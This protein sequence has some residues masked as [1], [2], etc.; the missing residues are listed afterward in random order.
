MATNIKANQEV[1][2]VFIKDEMPQ[3]KLNP[4]AL[5]SR[6]ETRPRNENFERVLRTEIH[7]PMFMLGR[8]WQLGEFTAEDTGSAIFAKI[9]MR[10]ASLSRFKAMNGAVEAFDPSIPLETKVER[11]PIQFNYKERVRMGDIWLKYVQKHGIEAWGAAFDFV[12]VKDDFITA[13]GFDAPDEITDEDSDADLVNKSKIISNTKLYEYLRLIAGRKIDGKLIYDL[14]Q[15][16][17]PEVM[18]DYGFTEAY[19]TIFEAARQDLV[20]WYNSAY[21]QPEGETNPCWNE[22]KYE[23]S[24]QAALPNHDNSINT[25]LDVEGYHSGQLRWKDFNQ[26]TNIANND[27]LVDPTYSA[28]GLAAIEGAALQ[29]VKTV[30]LLPVSAQFEG[31]ASNRWWQ[32]EN[33]KV[34]FGKMDANTTD[35]A[36]VVAAEFTFVHQDDWFV[37]PYEVP[38]GSLSEVTGIVVKDV[39]GQQTYVDHAGNGVD[40]WQD[41]SMYSL[42]GKDND[43]NS[44][45]EL[46]PADKRLF[47]P[48]SISKLMESEALEEVSY[49]RDEMANLVWAIESRIDNG[50]GEGVDGYQLANQLEAKLISLKPVLETPATGYVG[51][52]VRLS[53]KLGNTV[54][55][56]WIPF[57]PVHTDDN[58]RSIK[59]QR[60]AMPRYTPEYEQHLIRPRTNFLRK[61][62]DEN[63]ALLADTEGAIVKYF[64]HEEEVPREGVV[65]SKTIQRT[66]WFD[67]R[68]YVWQSTKKKIGRGE[69]NSSLQFDRILNK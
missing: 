46:L 53:Y 21:S 42:S 17:G 62:I 9:E 57:I 39:F 49:V 26:L 67:G 36:K 68:T 27:D 50:L 2:G 20:F 37:V 54:P 1:N 41:W 44:P 63:D 66:R 24:F 38:V 33:G 15:A 4:Y 52:D 11:M 64:I 13:F 69:A 58:L 55:E 25:A 47:F 23:Y 59:L 14:L 65:L 45:L 30:A 43:L 35:L 8:Q 19:E 18:E 40:S 5:W 10:S 48:P 34:N 56:N 22:E 3:G 16:I 32:F 7:D 31:M 28:P 12:S 29:P 60:A 51:D 6:L 61:G